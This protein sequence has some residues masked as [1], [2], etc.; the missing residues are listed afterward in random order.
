MLALNPGLDFTK[1]RSDG[2]QIL[3]ES[4]ANGG[5]RNRVRDAVGGSV[6]VVI[7][8][9]MAESLTDA[10]MTVA[11]ANI[12][13]TDNPRLTLHFVAEPKA[14]GVT[15]TLFDG[16]PMPFLFRTVEEWA[17]L[18]PGETFVAHRGRGFAVAGP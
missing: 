9:F 14:N 17:A 1:T 11:L 10:E 3:N 12:H 16:T 4:L 7:S 6:D 15:R 18:Y 2:L 5:S 13:A 8:E